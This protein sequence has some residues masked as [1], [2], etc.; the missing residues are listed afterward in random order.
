LC[1]FLLVVSTGLDVSSFGEELSLVVRRPVAYAIWTMSVLACV[2][3]AYFLRT[4]RRLEALPTLPDGA[5]LTVLQMV[6]LGFPK[7]LTREYVA[8]LD[9]RYR[10][11]EY[12]VGLAWLVALVCVVA[13]CLSRSSFDLNVPPVGL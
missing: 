4:K 13:Y 2:W 7:V 5:Q 10:A 12:I 11:M 9:R 1:F 3:R 6:V 8:V